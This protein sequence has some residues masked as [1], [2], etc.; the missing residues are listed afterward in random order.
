MFES[1]ADRFEVGGFIDPNSGDSS[2]IGYV[3]RPEVRQSSYAKEQY[4]EMRALL[5]LSD[6]SRSIEWDFVGTDSNHD[7]IHYNVAK[8]DTLIEHLTLMREE[9]RFYN[10]IIAE[11]KAQVDKHNKKVRKENK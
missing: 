10:T 2:V 1:K 7:N 6:C 4:I 11:T 8:M 3:T 9:M 5:R